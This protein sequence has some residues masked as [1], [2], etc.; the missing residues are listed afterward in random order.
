MKTAVDVYGKNI[1][2]VVLTGMGHDGAEGIAKIKTKGGLTIAQDEETCAVY[3]MSK[4]V[5]DEGLA[6]KVL[7]I[8]D[9]ADE[10]VRM[11][12]DGK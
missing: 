12:D 1:I 2:G 9:I 6:D 5:I 3:G 8:G 10:I 4:T 11:V 7:P